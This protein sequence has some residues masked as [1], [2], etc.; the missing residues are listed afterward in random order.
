MHCAWLALMFFVIAP[1]AILM[2][3]R[4]RNRAT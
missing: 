1:L 2:P 4:R 3:P